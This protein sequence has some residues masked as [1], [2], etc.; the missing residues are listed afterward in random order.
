MYDDL[1]RQLR[2]RAVN[3]KEKF[4]R[5][6]ELLSE[7][8]QAVDA[9]EELQEYNAALNDRILNLIW[10]IAELNKHYWIPMTERLPEDGLRCLVTRY[11]YV[12]ETSFVDLLWF[13]NGNWW[14]RYFPGEY[15][16]THWMPLPEP[17]K[18]EP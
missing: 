5:N 10:Q 3:L 6:A 11:D 15:A 17:Q 12:T 4:S 14:D 1:V 16:V 18:E 2:R 8:M 13:D 7:L 9:I